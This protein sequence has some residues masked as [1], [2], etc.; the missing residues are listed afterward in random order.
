MKDKSNLYLFAIGGTGAR[1]VRS[2]T[3]LLASG[4]LC[5]SSSS[6][7]RHTDIVLAE[8]T[9]SDVNSIVNDISS[10]SILI[11]TE[12]IGM[13]YIR[14]G[15]TKSE[16]FITRYNK[17]STSDDNTNDIAVI[18]WQVISNGV[19]FVLNYTKES[20][21]VFEKDSIYPANLYKED[22]NNKQKYAILLPS[23]EFIS[24]NQ[25]QINNNFIEVTKEEYDNR[26]NE[27]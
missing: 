25:E 21:I 2:L 15:K 7:V 16:R 12:K 19:R 5:E 22:Y 9:G 13:Y 27:L 4:K 1:V 11:V 14:Q 20:N 3:M 6:S 8:I 23:Y 10:H 17:L 18:S 26:T 24:L